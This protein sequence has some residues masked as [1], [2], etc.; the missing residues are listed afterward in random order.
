[1]NKKMSHQKAL[2]THVLLMIYIIS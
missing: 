1:M 2:M